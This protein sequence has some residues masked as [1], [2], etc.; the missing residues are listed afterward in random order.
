MA[1]A[2]S[3]AAEEWDVQDLT[4]LNAAK[5]DPTWQAEWELLA[6]W[7]AVDVWLPY[8]YDRGTCLLQTDATATRHDAAR[9]AGRTPAMSAS[10]AE[11]ALR[12]ESSQGM[13][14]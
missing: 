11:L 6:V 5:G 3:W 8:I 9:L 2:A 4:L 7:V 12:L 10:A 14:H 13:C 1:R